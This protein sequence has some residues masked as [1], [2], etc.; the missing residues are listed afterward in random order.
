MCYKFSAV[1]GDRSCRPFSAFRFRA[2]VIDAIGILKGKA[3]RL[4][5]PLDDAVATQGAATE[6]IAAIHRV[7]RVYRVPF[8]ARDCESQGKVLYRV[9]PPCRQGVPGRRPR[10]RRAQAVRGIRGDAVDRERAGALG[11]L[12]PLAGQDVEQTPRASLDRSHW[13]PAGLRSSRSPV[14]W[15]LRAPTAA[16]LARGRAGL[17]VAAQRIRRTSTNYEVDTKTS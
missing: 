1:S 17:P 4:D 12:A 9:G 14:G 5:P 8:P 7:R 6:L 13:V 16:R 11:L 2:L 10:L 3:R 15:S